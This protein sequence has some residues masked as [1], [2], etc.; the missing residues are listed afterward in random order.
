MPQV[1]EKVL[2]VLV[3]ERSQSGL[4]YVMKALKDAK[5]SNEVAAFTDIEQACSYVHGR[6]PIDIILLDYDAPQNEGAIFLDLI[7]TDLVRRRI[8]VVM[9]TE[10]CDSDS[11]ESIRSKGA[12][13]Y[14]YKT[15]DYGQFLRHIN[16]LLSLHCLRAYPESTWVGESC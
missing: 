14:I 15:K 6:N 3:V 8:P 9:L 10:A 12:S 5:R 2:N 7:C 13:G 11:I 4:D 1:E 16:S